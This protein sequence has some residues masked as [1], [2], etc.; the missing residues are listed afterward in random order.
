MG[1]EQCSRYE[2]NVFG[3]L[4]PPECR[5]AGKLECEQNLLYGFYVRGLPVA[6]FSPVLGFHHLTFSIL[7]K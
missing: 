5:W 4:Q 7:A 2:N 6:F 3:L 1:R